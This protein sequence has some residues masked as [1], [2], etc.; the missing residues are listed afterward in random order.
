MTVY[1]EAKFVEYAIRACLPYV[2]DLVIVEGAYVET[3]KLG[4]SPR[5]TDGTLNVIHS[6]VGDP[7]V[8]IIEAN[9][10]SDKDQ[11]NRGLEIIKQI[12]PD[13]WV[14]IVDGDE[15]YDPN[16]IN[17]IKMTANNLEKQGRLAAYF[18]SLTFV[19]DFSHYTEQT[20][21]RLFRITPECK[22]VNDN[23]MEWPD[24]GANWFGPFIVRLPYIKYFHY[25]FCKGDRFEL[26]KKWWETRFNKPFD[27]G[28]HRD[29]SGKIVDS[30]HEVYEFS[31]KH[32]DIM[33]AHPMYGGK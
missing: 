6:F 1:N 5:S 19:N 22:F 17:M 25:A 13:G 21:P 16:T 7:K 10:L 11:R 31:G 15:I 12:N 30:S 20:F 27:Y 14:L 33:K 3:V 9:E 4:A 28:W 24:K 29:E 18:K 2:D 32:P 23:F 8:R 26:K